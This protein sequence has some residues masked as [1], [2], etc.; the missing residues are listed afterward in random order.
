MLRR[1]EQEEGGRVVGVKW[2]LLV[3]LENFLSIHQGCDVDPINGLPSASRPRY[4]SQIP[5]AK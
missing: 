5:P 3:S 4:P 1:A 2:H